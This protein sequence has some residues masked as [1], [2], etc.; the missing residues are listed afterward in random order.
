MDTLIDLLKETT[1]KF[2]DSVA[3]EGDV[4]GRGRVTLT[5]R[6]LCGKAAALAREL[7]DAGVKPGDF[8]ALLALN[9]PEW[10]VGYYGALLAGGVLVPLDVNLKEGELANILETVSY[11]HLTLPTKRIV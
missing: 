3:L 5:R 2:P 11:T 4:E 9:Q 6:Q 8:V 7:I 10:G 1:A